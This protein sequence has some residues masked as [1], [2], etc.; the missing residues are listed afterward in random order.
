MSRILVVEDDKDIAELIAINLENLPAEITTVYEGRNGFLEA[1]SQKYDL[2][3][4][5]I[6]L[7]GMNGFDICKELRM[8]RITT[9]IIFLTSKSEEVDLLIGLESGADD[10]ITKPF[11]VRELQARV[12][13][14]LRRERLQQQEQTDKH[15]KSLFIKN[16]EINQ[17]KRKVLLDGELVNLTPK[18]YDLICYLAQ[19]A[20]ATFSRAQLLNSVWG[21]E[22][23]GYEHTVNSHINRLRG[24]IEKNP[25]E[26]E[27]ILTTWGVGYRFAE[28]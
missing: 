16:L 18:E 17:K 6:M 27:Y 4:L 19:H 3:L 9:P 14:T 25:N 2:I 8:N 12:K 15:L 24:K 7:P 21:H 28:E 10:Y 22:Y 23:V 1:A 26:P 11:S 13:A 5:D 20:G